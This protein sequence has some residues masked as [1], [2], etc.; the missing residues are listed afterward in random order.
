MTVKEYLIRMEEKLEE[1]LSEQLKEFIPNIIKNLE[2]ISLEKFI[3]EGDPI[4]ELQEF[5]KIFDDTLSKGLNDKLEDNRTI[6][7]VE[8][9]FQT[10]IIKD[11]EG[12]NREFSIG[13][14]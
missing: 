2:K 5:K 3:K 14:N 13:L 6:S 10:I 8:G 1:S 4:L 9:P 11:N 12:I 7:F